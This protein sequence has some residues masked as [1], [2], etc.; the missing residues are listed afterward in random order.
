M[1]ARFII[2]C[3]LVVSCVEPDPAPVA[4]PPPPV[5]VLKAWPTSYMALCTMPP[6]DRWD[7]LTPVEYEMI[8][9]SP[10]LRCMLGFWIPPEQLELPARY[11]RCV[12]YCS[13]GCEA[14]PAD[15]CDTVQGID[16]ETD[17]TR[18]YS[19]CGHGQK[20]VRG[21]RCVYNLNCEGACDVGGT[22]RCL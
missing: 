2:V 3:A 12:A 19:I 14:V 17:E 10:G 20:R 7:D 5:P 16:S 13:G 1:R 6:L 9:C 22:F 8:P 4:D 18:L 21:S 15:G 11:G